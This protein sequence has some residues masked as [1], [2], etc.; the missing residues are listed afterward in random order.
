VVGA[1]GFEWLGGEDRREG[2][3][4]GVFQ[5]VYLMIIKVILS[6]KNISKNTLLDKVLN[7]NDFICQLF[8]FIQL[9]SLM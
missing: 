7:I 6:D 2:F 4:E 1:V 9:N 5:G 8:T 3:G